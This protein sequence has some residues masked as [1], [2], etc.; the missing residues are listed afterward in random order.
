LSQLSL[1]FVLQP[2]EKVNK[3]KSVLLGKREGIIGEQLLKSSDIVIGE[4]ELIRLVTLLKVSDG[5][6]LVVMKPAYLRSNQISRFRLVW[7]SGTG[8]TA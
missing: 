7:M 2:G 6:L 8:S 4:Y 1:S 3:Q 5:F